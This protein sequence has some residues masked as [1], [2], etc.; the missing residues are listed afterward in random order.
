MTFSFVGFIWETVHV[1]LLAK[2]LVDRSFLFGPI[3][4]IYGTTMVI[5][6]LLMG[7]PQ[8]PKTFLKKTKGKWYQYLLY[9][10]IDISLPTLVELVVGLGCE[11]LFN[12]RLWDYSHYVINLFDKEIPLHYKGYIALPISCI[13][14]V[15]IFIS[16]GFVFPMLL[17]LIE[18]NPFKKIKTIFYDF[19]CYNGSRYNS[20]HSVCIIIKN[21]S[22][23]FVLF[24]YTK[25]KSK[26]LSFFSNIIV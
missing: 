5:S 6:Y 4:P 16:M 14:L 13:W 10:I 26:F 3:C 11:K 23:R 9:A 17:K 2:E 21:I 1:S 18:K 20:I 7:P 15:L 22:L 12:I 8:A 25:T 24:S 19:C